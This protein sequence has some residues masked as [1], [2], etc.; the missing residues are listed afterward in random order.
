[1]RLSRFLAPFLL[2]LACA[3]TSRT[4]EVLPLS[5]SI[6]GASQVKRIELVVR[7]QARASVAALDERAGQKKAEGGHAAA[8]LAQL[9]PDMIMEA[10][11]RLGLTGGRE[12]KLLLEIDEFE[13]ASA[14][15]AM[16]GV[17]DRL[18]GTVFV[19]D[20]GTGETLGQLYVDVNARASGLM[21]LATR[22]GVRERIAEAFATRVAKALSGR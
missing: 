17:E 20:A 12:L 5:R 13:T 7:P 10:T 11:R 18:A 2:L 3:C 16:F 9:L 14:G 4:D 6:V 1:L 22:G 21:G 8:P 15:A 19:S